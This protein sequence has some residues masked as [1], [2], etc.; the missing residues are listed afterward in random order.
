MHCCRGNVF[1]EPLPSN[2]SGCT[3]RHTDWWEGFMKY[4]IGMGSGAMIYAPRFIKIV[5]PTHRLQEHLRATVFFFLLPPA[6]LMLTGRVGVQVPRLVSIGSYLR[7][8]A[9]LSDWDR[10]KYSG[11]WVTN[12]HLDTQWLSRSS[13]FILKTP[14]LNLN[15]YKCRLSQDN[16]IQR[17]V[18]T[19]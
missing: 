14:L 4:A 16:V 11:F 6:V 3:C 19:N 13:W 15:L 1:S 5:Q 8:T 2:N 18:S 12:Y 17:F 7:D 9:C 10:K